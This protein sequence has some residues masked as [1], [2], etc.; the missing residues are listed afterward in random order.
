MNK[1]GIR[2]VEYKVLVKPEAVEAQTAG[3]LYIPDSAKEKEKYAKERG[4]IIAIGSIC[5]TDPNWLDYPKVGDKIL[6]DKYAGATVKGQDGEDY[7]L[8]SDKEIGAVIEG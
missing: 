5:F 1:S 6:F 2:P 4:D 8:I 3:G 7:R